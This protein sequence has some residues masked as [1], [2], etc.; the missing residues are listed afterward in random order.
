MKLY[1]IDTIKTKIIT[2]TIYTLNTNY[3]MQQPALYFV[4]K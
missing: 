1:Y 4:D 3:S 2:I